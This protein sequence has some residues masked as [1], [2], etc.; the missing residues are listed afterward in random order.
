MLWYLH[1][2]ANAGIVVTRYVDQA[3]GSMLENSDGS[4]QFVEAVLRPEV[5]VADPSMTS[6]AMQL[7]DRA[8][9]MCFIARSVNFP[10]RHEPTVL[11]ETSIDTNSDAGHAVGPSGMRAD[12]SGGR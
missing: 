2:A 6:L 12:L 1:L 3:R 9:A 8:H 11:V 5:T 10:V 7:H 4:G